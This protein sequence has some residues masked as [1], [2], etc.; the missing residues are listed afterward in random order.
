MTCKFFFLSL[1]L[2]KIDYYLKMNFTEKNYSNYLVSICC[3]LCVKVLL[4]QSQ[5]WG[6]SLLCGRILRNVISLWIN[7][8]IPDN[9]MNTEYVNCTYHLHCNVVFIGKF[10]F[11]T[12]Q[13]LFGRKNKQKRCSTEL[14]QL[15]IYINSFVIQ[16]N[17][18]YHC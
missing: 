18:C 5:I 14:H 17:C 16:Y 6:Q 3:F 7:Y 11:V 8:K 2:K 10:N 12:Y 15:F 1:K 13:N 9:S 4:S